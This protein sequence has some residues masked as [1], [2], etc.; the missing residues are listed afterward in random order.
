MTSLSTRFL[1]Q[2]KVTRA[3]VPRAGV[4]LDGFIAKGKR[5][6]GSG[7]DPVEETGEGNGLADVLG[8][9]DPGHGPFH[10]EAEPRVRRRPELSQVE[11]PLIGFARQV[12]LPDA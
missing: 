3:T 8:T 5:P 12:L 10:S 7:I 6:P 1:A 2:P 4:S 11:V 9:A